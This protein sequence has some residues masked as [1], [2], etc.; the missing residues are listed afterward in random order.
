MLLKWVWHW[1][2][3]APSTSLG[4]TALYISHHILVLWANLRTSYKVDIDKNFGTLGSRQRAVDALPS[5]S[6][7]VE[8]QECPLFNGFFQ[9]IRSIWYKNMS[10]HSSVLY[11]YL[12]G[13]KIVIECL[14]A[15]DDVSATA[16][17]V[18]QNGENGG[19]TRG[20]F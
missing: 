19:L 17:F 15:H 4:I 9:K 1:L 16:T 20:Q 13:L 8:G 2:F 12:Y 11:S 18:L 6:L 5:P 14:F 10:S 7:V 3:K